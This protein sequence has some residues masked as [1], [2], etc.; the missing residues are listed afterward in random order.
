MSSLARTKQE[1]D[2]SSSKVP[3]R[4]KAVLRKERVGIAVATAITAAALLLLR[5]LPPVS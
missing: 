5:Q 1:A 3:T 2:N 4:L